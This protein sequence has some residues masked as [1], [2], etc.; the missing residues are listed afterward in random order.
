LEGVGLGAALFNVHYRKAPHP[1]FC[2]GAGFW[3]YLEISLLPHIPNFR[4]VSEIESLFVKSSTAS[5]RALTAATHSKAKNECG[6][7][8]PNDLICDTLECSAEYAQIPSQ[9]VG[10]AIAQ[11]TFNRAVRTLPDGYG[12]RQQ[13]L[14]FWRQRHQTCT[15]VSRIRLDSE[16]SAALERLQGCRQSRPIH[17][18]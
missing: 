15:A 14:P 12:T 6:T 8:R 13:F 16:Q 7:R 4:N 17:Q 10:L 9:P 18:Q 1:T 3:R 11:Q 5:N 2:S